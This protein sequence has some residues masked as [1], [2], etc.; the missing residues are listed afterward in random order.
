MYELIQINAGCMLATLE[1]RCD[2]TL[3]CYL[4]ACADQESFVR[5]GSTQKTFCFCF[6]WGGERQSK[7]HYNWA[8][9]GPPAKRHLNGI[10]LTSHWRHFESGLVALWFFKESGPVLLRNIIFLCFFRGS[11]PPVPLSGSAHLHITK[12]LTFFS[13][14]SS[15]R[16]QTQ[17]CC[18]WS[19]P[20]RRSYQLLTC[21]SE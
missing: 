20:S 11:G 6:S 9:I 5:G 1:I 12:G 14:I 19:L 13:R 21:S 15:R 16:N 8:I 4:H 17:F 18:L 10:S 2:I 3:F 7:Y